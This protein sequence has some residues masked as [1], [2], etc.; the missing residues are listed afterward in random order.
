MAYG[1]CVRNAESRATLQLVL[2]WMERITAGLPARCTPLYFTDMNA[3]VGSQPACNTT[4]TMMI[5]EHS[6]EIENRHGQ[7]LRG[8]ACRTDTQLLKTLHAT[9]AGATWS[10]GR[11]LQSRPDYIMKGANTAGIVTRVWI[12][13]SLATEIQ[14]SS[15]P[16]WMDH[17]PVCMDMMY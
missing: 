13:Y 2:D 1:P 16:R 8:W 9:S 3:R 10:G 15:A 14:L 5:G 12:D 6:A 11:G 4:H 7:L 17:A